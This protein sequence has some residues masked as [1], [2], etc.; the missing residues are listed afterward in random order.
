MSSAS[1]QSSSSL[2]S[3]LSCAPRIVP[4][5][6]WYAGALKNVP[7][8][9]GSK[10]TI[11]TFAMNLPCEGSATYTAFSTVWTG[12][13]NA[14]ITKWG[15]IGITRRRTAGSA[16]VV[17]YLKY[18][19]M[20]GPNPAD[21]HNS[22]HNDP[23]FPAIG[24]TQEYECVV[25]PATGRWDFFVGG[26][27]KDNFTNAGWK[28]QSGDRVDFT[29]EIYDLGSQMTG[30]VGAKCNIT[31]CQYKTGSAFSSSSSSGLVAGGYVSA[32]LAAGNINVTDATE[33]GCDL[34]SADAIR[35]WDVNP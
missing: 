30:T 14:G 29:A 34:V 26:V 8:L 31:G 11:D 6:Y 9:L 24:T 28:N 20:A 33:H 25:D 10:A 2:S 7:L 19:V 16:A 17:Q 15:Q 5:D 13:T 27:A 12:I 32:G 4:H 35:V 3:S 18:E 23:D 21:Y 22:I 1:A